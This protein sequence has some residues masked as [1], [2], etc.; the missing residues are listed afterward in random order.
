MSATL[1]I[2]YVDDEPD[3]RTIAV[4]ALELEEGLSV[5]AAA[6]GVEALALVARENLRPGVALLD[7]MMPGMDGPALLAEL[8]E[9]PGFETIPVIFMTAKARDDDVARYRELGAIGVVSKPFDP[10]TLAAEVRAL[11]AIAQTD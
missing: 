2:L 5:H 11:L 8:R 7:V 9:E 1:E 10:M 4:M 3:I 6:S